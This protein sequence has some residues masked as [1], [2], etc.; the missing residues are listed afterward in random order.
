MATYQGFGT[1]NS[2]NYF[3]SADGVGGYLPG[4]SSP[5]RLV[6]SNIDGTQTWVNGTGLSMNLSSMSLTSLTS[7]EHRTSG[8]DLIERIDNFGGTIGTASP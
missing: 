4:L 8:G 2:T 6:F 7:I 3:W 1:Y 5:T